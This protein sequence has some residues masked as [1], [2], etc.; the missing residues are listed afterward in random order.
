MQAKF[1]GSCGDR[2]AI[3]IGSEAKGRPRRPRRNPLLPRPEKIIGRKINIGLKEFSERGASHSA[4]SGRSCL[5]SA[6]PPST[7]PSPYFDFQFEIWHSDKGS[8]AFCIRMAEWP[9]SVMTRARMGL[10]RWRGGLSE[11][12][13]EEEEGKEGEKPVWSDCVY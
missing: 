5:E 2:R 4:R 3:Q 7:L 13:E 12:K 1:L 10:R 11:E 9:T 6:C 8:A